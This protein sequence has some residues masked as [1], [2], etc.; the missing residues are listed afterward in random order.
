MRGSSD[1]RAD[2]AHLLD[3]LHADPLTRVI[4]IQERID[5]G[6]ELAGMHDTDDLAEVE[7]ESWCG[8]A[9]QQAAR[10]QLCRLAPSR[11]RRQRLEA[12][13]DHLIQMIAPGATPSLNEERI[14]LRVQSSQHRSSIAGR[15]RAAARCGFNGETFLVQGGPVRIVKSWEFGRGSRAE[16][17]L[18]LAAPSAPIAPLAPVPQ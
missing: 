3:R 13:R 6:E 4:L 9:V 11:G 10:D 8:V 12:G 17:S 1:A 5:V 7:H 15:W 14:R 16:R 2:D 18:D